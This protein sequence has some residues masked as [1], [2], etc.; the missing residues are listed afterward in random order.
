MILCDLKL[1]SFERRENMKN[2]SILKILM[3]MM[4]VEKRKEYKIMK[5]LGIEWREEE[6]KKID[7]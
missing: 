5:L 6:K 7:D 2:H 3:M 4:M 1:F